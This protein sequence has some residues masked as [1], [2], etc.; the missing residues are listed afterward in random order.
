MTGSPRVTRASILGASVLGR[1]A[2]FLRQR[3]RR[4][5]ACVS[6]WWGTG[7]SRTPAHPGF[8]EKQARLRRFDR[9]AALGQRTPLLPYLGGETSWHDQKGT[10]SGLSVPRRRSRVSSDLISAPTRRLVTCGQERSSGTVEALFTYG[11][12]SPVTALGHD[13][14]LDLATFYWANRQ[15]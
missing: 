15:P 6:V 2:R 7:A 13:R 5:R 12:I 8:H 4:P 14:A 3:R 10:L 11:Q 9:R 1:F